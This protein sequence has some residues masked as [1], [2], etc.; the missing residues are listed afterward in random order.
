[1]RYC[2]AA[3]LILTGASVAMPQEVPVRCDDVADRAPL[4]PMKLPGS[5]YEIW[6]G[7]IE[8]WENHNTKA[9]RRIPLHVIVIPA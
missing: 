9:G 5:S 1:M 2:I 7:N 6:A 3:L 8:V 4:Q